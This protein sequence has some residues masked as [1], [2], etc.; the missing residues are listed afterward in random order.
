[1]R[2]QQLGGNLNYQA[3]INTLKRLNICSDACRTR[4]FQLLKYQT[5]SICDHNQ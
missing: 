4:L 3:N 2:H 5:E 1:M